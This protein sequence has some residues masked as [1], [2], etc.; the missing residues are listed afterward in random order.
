[1]GAI[2]HGICLST[3]NQNNISHNH[4]NNYTNINVRAA[5]AHV[6]GDLLQSI[7]VLIAAIIIKIYPNL[8]HADPICTILF[9]IIA[10]IVTRKVAKDSI[11]ILME[12]SPRD[13][14]DVLKI[15]RS[16]PGVMHVHNLHVW[17][18]S[19]GRDSVTAHLAVG[20]YN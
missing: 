4:N 18:I 12:T 13:T 16:I 3:H 1:M 19:P 8:K 20:E 10:V 15:F 17:T 14:K 11:R 5:I 6:I 2:L 7:G 9:T